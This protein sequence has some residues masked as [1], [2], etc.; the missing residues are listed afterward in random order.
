MNTTVAVTLAICFAVCFLAVSCVGYIVREQRERGVIM[1]EQTIDVGKTYVEMNIKTNIPAQCELWIEGREPKIHQGPKL[2]E[3]H[4]IIMDNLNAGS[5][6][7]YVLCIFKGS[8][9]EYNY[10]EYF[11]KGFFVTRNKEKIK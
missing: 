8:K 10:S 4:H 9:V 3:Q 5:T 2:S 6:Y 11:K 7:K 1:L